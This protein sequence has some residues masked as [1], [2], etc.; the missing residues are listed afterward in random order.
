MNTFS[1]MEQ[2]T[3]EDLP[4]VSAYAVYSFLSHPKPHSQF[5]V[6][7]HKHFRHL[8]LIKRSPFKMHALL[9]VRL[10]FRN[11][12]TFSLL[13]NMTFSERPRSYFSRLQEKNS[14]NTAGCPLSLFN[15]PS[16]HFPQ[17]T[18]ITLLIPRI[19]VKTCK[20]IP[21]MLRKSVYHERKF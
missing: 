12:P 7:G 9:R 19:K 21:I 6:L 1:P 17:Q 8:N 13:I 16:T 18:L 3:C 20:I 10:Y 2:W 11:T 15:H 4:T 5:S 14:S